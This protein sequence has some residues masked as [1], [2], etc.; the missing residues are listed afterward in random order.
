MLVVNDKVIAKKSS[1]SNSL[2]IA[3]KLDI[4]PK[5]KKIDLNKVVM[6]EEGKFKPIPLRLRTSQMRYWRGAYLQLSRRPT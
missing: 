6:R 3:R 4:K 1:M 2:F 5:M